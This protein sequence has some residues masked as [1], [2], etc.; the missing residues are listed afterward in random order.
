MYT[1]RNTRQSEV[2]KIKQKRREIQTYVKP[3]ITPFMDI[4]PNFHPSPAGE[5]G[6]RTYILCRIVH[7]LKTS[8]SV[9]VLSFI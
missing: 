3:Y 8:K 2:D 1:S 4:V 7:F 5:S 6:S 9:F